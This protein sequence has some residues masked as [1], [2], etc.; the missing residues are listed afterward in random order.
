MAVSGRGKLAPPYWEFESV[1][2][3]ALLP[4]TL[5]H[6]LPK[7]VR[8]SAPPG[9]GKTVLLAELYRLQADRRRQCLWITLDDRDTTV[10]SLIYLLDVALAEL[11]RRPVTGTAV[12]IRE[13]GGYLASPEAVIERLFRLQDAVVLFIDNLQFCTDRQLGPFIDRLLFGSRANLRMVLASTS[14]IPVDL[15]RARLEMRDALVGVEQLRFE[16]GDTERLFKAAS[17]R[18]P[19]AATLAYIQ[20]QTE[21]WPA[22]VRLLQ[23]LV[24]EGWTDADV[25]TRFA[26]SETDVAEVLLERVLSGFDPSMVRFMQELAFLREFSVALAAQ[27]TG[28]RRAQEWIEKLIERNVLVFPLDRGHRWLRM[29]TLL[30]QQ[31]IEQGRLLVPE[32]RRR[33]VLTHAAEWHAD[34]GDLPT[35]IDLALEAN[36][37]HEACRWIE[38]VC[39]V[40]VGD[41]GRF[42]LYIRWVDQLLADA[43]PL[44]LDIHVWYVWSLCF[45]LQYERARSAINAIDRLAGTGGARSDDG[46][47]AMRLG[48][49]RVIVGINLDAIEPAHREAVRWLESDCA[50]DALS[51][52]TV[53]SGAALAELAVGDLDAAMGHMDTAEGAAERAGS[54]YG[55]AWVTTVK[56]CIH[57]AQGDPSSARSML[58]AVR[59]GVVAVVG[60]DSHAVA[61][62]DFVRARALL[63]VAAVDDARA[64]ARKGLRGAS[65]HGVVDTVAQ[66]LA[67]CVALGGAKGSGDFADEALNGVARVYPPRL[68]RMLGAERVRQLL[69]SGQVDDAWALARRCRLHEPFADDR[70]AL[71]GVVLLARLE[72]DSAG[73]GSSSMRTRIADAI[74][75]AQEQG[76]RRDLVE[77]HLL[78]CNLSQR[79][80]DRR[81]ATRHLSIAISEAAE[82][83]LAWPFLCRIAQLSSLLAQVRPR[84]LGATRP[85]DV[86][87]LEMLHHAAGRGDS[88][89]PRTDGVQLEALTRSEMQL[90]EL[91]SEGLSNPEISDRTSRSLQTV[92]WHLKNLYGKLGVKNRSAALV[93]A[94]ALHILGP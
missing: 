65:L 6:E 92:K 12:A 4:L 18:L 67:C 58:E 10:A 3:K 63:D 69:R 29:H 47:R 2:P 70:V 80:G 77:L 41:Q 27:C 46:E 15:A 1:V 19:P 17:V 79:E 24:G 14:S 37:V 54:P 7:L 90:L 28:E 73:G 43:V 32:M 13:V 40:V 11:E 88:S 31:L 56:A 76:R 82:R 55:R 68:G 35:A 48:T 59:P 5:M 26:G 23:V 8:V 34:H 20:S 66:G 57:L 94:R 75:R 78:A 93:K 86:A 91:L 50:P 44:S 33:E 25:H 72:L 61:L 16:S 62:M 89:P 36:A 45:S 51:L 87:F 21:G 30:R 52:A 85:D 64:A 71:H 60:E 39:R 53:A 81:Q 38:K 74:K 49:M 42:A 83:Q 9:Y 22:A 84:D